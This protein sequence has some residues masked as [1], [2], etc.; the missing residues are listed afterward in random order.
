MYFIPNITNL[1]RL[2]N[3]P[4]AIKEGKNP[5]IV[6]AIIIMGLKAIIKVA[7]CTSKTLWY[8]FIQINQC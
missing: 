5:I 7:N 3:A 2:S 6:E 4:V 8:L 1:Q